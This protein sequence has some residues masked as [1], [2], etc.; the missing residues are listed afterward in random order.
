[1]EKDFGQAEI[2]TKL[3]PLQQKIVIEL[4]TGPLTLNE[5][6]NRTNSSVYTIGKQLS[7][8]QGRTKCCFLQKKGF[9]E[10]IV[11]KIKEERIKTTYFLA[12]A[13]F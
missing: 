1:M 5:I 4:K 7:L 6:S 12:L 13:D 10:P 3:S 11:K 2:L 9:K 8:L